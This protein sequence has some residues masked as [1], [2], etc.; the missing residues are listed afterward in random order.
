[1]FQGVLG[2]PPTSDGGTH[3]ADNFAVFFRD[4]VEAV[5]NSTAATSLYNVP[6]RVTPTITQWATVTVD[7]VQKLIRSALNKT[8]QLDP[9]INFVAI[10]VFTQRQTARDGN[11]EHLQGLDTSYVWQR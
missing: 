9:A 2:E 7:E 6:H 4:K 1:M 5:R 11:T 10:H 8:C 3:T